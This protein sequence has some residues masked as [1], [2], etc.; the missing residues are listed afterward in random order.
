MPTRK[1]RRKKVL[2]RDDDYLKPKK[3]DNFEL[4]SQYIPNNSYFN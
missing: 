2:Y 4:K 3:E 1:I